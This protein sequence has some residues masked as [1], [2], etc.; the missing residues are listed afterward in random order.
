MRHWQVDC[1]LPGSIRPWGYSSPVGWFAHT[2]N[3][4]PAHRRRWPRRSVIAARPASITTIRWISWILH[5]H[6]ICH[7]SSDTSEEVSLRSTL[8]AVASS[9]WSRKSLED[10]RRSTS[11]GVLP[12][13]PQIYVWSVI[14]L[15]ALS[16]LATSRLRTLVSHSRR[17][18]APTSSGVTS[19][20]CR[21]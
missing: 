12:V 16:R 20:L 5:S 6:D 15:M 2:P 21:T 17:L 3:D 10:F 8:T 4:R 13:A 11:P 18:N 19:P 14:P 9:G 1:T 7:V